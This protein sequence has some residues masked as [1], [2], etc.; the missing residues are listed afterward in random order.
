ME[1]KQMRKILIGLLILLVACAPKNSVPSILSGQLCGK[2]CWNGIT[3]GKTS[4]QELMSILVNLTIVDQDSIVIFDE[5]DGLFDSMIFFSL[6]EESDGEHPNVDVSVYTRDQKVV[7]IQ[8]GGDLGIR[9][10][11]VI[12]AF[13]EP[14]LVSAVWDPRGGIDIRFLNKLQGLNFGYI[15]KSE[16][17][18]ISSDVEIIDLEL[19]DV[20]IYQTL[21]ESN[22]LTLGYGEFILYPWSGYGKIEEHYWPPR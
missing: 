15:A 8:F 16:S 20:N 12:D 18:R 22:W 5:S 1:Y 9:F 14:E 17:A 2:S 4:Q 10:Q 19:F 6:Y 3:V 13:G 11:D 21:L 7:A